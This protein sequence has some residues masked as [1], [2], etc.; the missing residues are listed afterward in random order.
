MTIV[1]NTAHNY[2]FEIDVD[3][4]LKGQVSRLV[5]SANSSATAGPGTVLLLVLDNNFQAAIAA[6]DITL[7]YAASDITWLN[8]VISYL[9]GIL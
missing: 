4:P 2:A 5:I 8:N 6:G 7:Q 9:V 3:S 1:N